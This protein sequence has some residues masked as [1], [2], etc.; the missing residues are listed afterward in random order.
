MKFFSSS[1]IKDAIALGRPKHKGFVLSKK[2]IDEWLDYLE[3]IKGI[4]DIELKGEN[5]LCIN[6]VNIF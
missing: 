2:W 5:L 3:Q 4:I 6:T 1:W